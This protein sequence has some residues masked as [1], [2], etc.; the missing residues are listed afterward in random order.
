MIL[1]IIYVVIFS[2]SK[3]MRSFITLKEALSFIEENNLKDAKVDCIEE[4]S[5]GYDMKFGKVNY[6]NALSTL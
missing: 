3:R 5:T 2:N 1:N 4:G 6:E